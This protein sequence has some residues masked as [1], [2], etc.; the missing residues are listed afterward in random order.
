MYQCLRRLPNTTAAT[1]LAMDIMLGNLK[2]FLTAR[3][4]AGVNELKIGS[5][6]AL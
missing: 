4:E 1:K 6:R 3:G 2:G 5:Q